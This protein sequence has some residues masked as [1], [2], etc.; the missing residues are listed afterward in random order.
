M[1]AS[2]IPSRCKKILNMDF[3]KLV[4]S[5]FYLVNYN[6]VSLA[7]ALV[8]PFSAYLLIEVLAH[9]DVP[10]G[11]G[12]VLPVLGW[13]VYAIIAIT[14]H[15]LVLLG[16]NSIPEWGIRSWSMRETY[17]LLHMLGIG[18]I[19]M[20]MSVLVFIPIAGVLALLLAVCWILPRL[21]LV[22]PGIAVDKGVT[23]ELS[24][25]LT[26]N[27]QM[28]MFLIVIA[29][30]VV[31]SIPALLLMLIPYGYLLSSVLSLF[32]VVI[33]IAVLSITYKQITSEVYGEKEPDTFT[34]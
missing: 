10:D 33:E 32:V 17:F 16:P 23:F 8:I 14:T 13:A 7:K 18:L 24:W 19:A 20:A 9:L 11:I 2:H 12:W 29:L 27:Y 6:R 5:A 21:S 4:L 3:Q 26:K 1:E 15:R 34:R 30:P 28:D 25:K 31:L 22:F